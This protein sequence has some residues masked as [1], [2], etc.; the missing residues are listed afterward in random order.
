MINNDQPI[1]PNVSSEFYRPIE[2]ALDRAVNK[3]DCKSYSD[4]M[5]LRAGVGRVIDAAK[6]GRAWVQHI[7]M[8]GVITVSVRNFF[9]ALSSKRRLKLLIEIDQDVRDQ[10]NQG[11]KEIGDPFDEIP[12][13][14]GF[15]VYASDGHSHGASAHEK[16]IFGKKRA[17]NHI[18]SL[19][20]RS[21]AMSHLALTEPAKGKKKE[22]EITAIKR[23]G[24]PAL[25]FGA[26]KGT[27]VIHAY[28]PAIADYKEW[29][30]WKQG[31]GVYIITS[32]KSNSAFMVLGIHEW[33]KLDKRNAGVTSDELVSTSR[34]VS[35]RRI[36]YTDPVHATDYSFITTEMT[37]PPGIIAFIYKMRWNIEK[38]FDEFKN[39]F[40]QQKAWG[41]S[42]TTK[43]QQA[44]F[45]VLTHNLLVL[46]ENRLEIVEGIVDDKVRKK[47]A[48]YIAAGINQAHSGFRVPNE[49]VSKF[50]RVTKRSLQFIRW[51]QL[52]LIINP[53]W[54]IA[55]EQLRP[56]MQEYLI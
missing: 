20:L 5:F 40:Y 19:N 26:P 50:S 2:S 33:D 14:M 46:L 27:K 29:A 54:R 25:R 21:N 38:V 4:A 43:C 30:K 45:M 48:R 55:V 16:D 12:E 49:L 34:G 56:L 1:Q 8:L 22:H 9:I 17:V 11:L 6:S 18:F 44:L 37:L 39:T 7:L 41:K 24:G 3:R 10:I 13:L 53:P 52:G 15:E 35:I 28:D 47:H 42:S 32:E 31:S 23:Q 51:L 36:R